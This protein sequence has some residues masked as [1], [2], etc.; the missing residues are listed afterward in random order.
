MTDQP[1]PDHL[2]RWTRN[3]RLY[4]HLL[5]LGLWVEPIVEGEKGDR[6]EYLRVAVSQPHYGHG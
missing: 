3:R 2:D 5:S 4:N 1:P 6:I